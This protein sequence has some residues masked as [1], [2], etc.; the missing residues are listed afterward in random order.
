MR[1]ASRAVSG[2]NHSDHFLNT[3]WRGFS[4]SSGVYHNASLNGVLFSVV[5]FFVCK[6]K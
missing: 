1:Y 2:W 5:S 3:G 6:G 4:L